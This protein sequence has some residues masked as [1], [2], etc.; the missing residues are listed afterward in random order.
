M[1]QPRV[2]KHLLVSTALVLFA[3]MT[4]G[5]EVGTSDT[6]RCWLV[7]AL[8]FSGILCFFFSSLNVQLEK[9]SVKD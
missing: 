2:L 7:I 3:E 4:P 1:A 9:G 6:N 5:A 8:N